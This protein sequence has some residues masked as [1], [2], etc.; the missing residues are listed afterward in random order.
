MAVFRV[1]KT[2]GY[3]VMSNY[4]LRDKNL[5]CKACGL[6]SK[7][8]SLPDEWD[9]TTR[10]LAMICKDGVESVTSALKELEECG[11]LIRRQNRDEKGRMAN[12]EYVIFEHPHKETVEN[13]TSDSNSAVPYT[14]APEPGNPYTVAPCPDGKAQIN[15][16]ISSTEESSTEKTSK[17]S[18]SFVPFSP[19]VNAREDAMDDPL[20][21]LV[22]NSR[23]GRTE[24]RT[25]L[26]PAR[27]REEIRERI[28]E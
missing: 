5:S 4:H 12:T 20:D 13:N 23:E 28:D 9:Y 7:M 25:E 22:E 2:T 19:S 21:D 1:E 24:G 11:Y 14:A 17:D 18:R 27:A 16:D 6:L 3:T 26:S 8:L 15:K 10:G